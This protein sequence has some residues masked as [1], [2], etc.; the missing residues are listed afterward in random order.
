MNAQDHVIFGG[1]LHDIDKFFAKEY[2][3][4]NLSNL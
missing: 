2:A 3:R 1:L 4:N